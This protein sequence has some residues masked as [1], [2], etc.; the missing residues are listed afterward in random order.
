MATLDD[1]FKSDLDENKKKAKML[2]GRLL[3]GL[4]KT[5][6]IKLYSLLESVNE[7]DMTEDKIILTLSD[8]VSFD[9]LN[10]KNDINELT[11]LMGNIQAG[12]KVELLC[13][14]KEPFDKFKFEQFLKDEFGNLLTIKRD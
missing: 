11:E 3:I 7:T 13:N 2:F 1:I 4:R 14:G 12:L 5:N 8:K 10:N 6:H 9:M